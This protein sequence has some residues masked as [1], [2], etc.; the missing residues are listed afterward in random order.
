MFRVILKAIFH[1][2]WVIALK[3][4]RKVLH[5]TTAFRSHH[6]RSATLCDAHRRE[7]ESGCLAAAR[8]SPALQRN[9]ALLSK[10][11]ML[12]RA[13]LPQSAGWSH[14][15]DVVMLLRSIPQERI[16]G[17]ISMKNME[18]KSKKTQTIW[19]WIW[20]VGRLPT[21]QSES[22]KSQHDETMDLCLPNMK[23]P[24]RIRWLGS[25]NTQALV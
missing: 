23:A 19:G 3:T 17:M 14:I 22:G 25:T 16:L 9:A 11:E 5:E 8:S 4:Q 13:P 15:H 20:V 21:R 12:S 2:E 6:N 7:G 18:V 10:G 24:S 1:L